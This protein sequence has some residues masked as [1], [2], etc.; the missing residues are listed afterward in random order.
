MFLMEVYGL[1]IE[2]HVFK[3]HPTDMLTKLSCDLHLSLLPSYLDF[4]NCNPGVGG[5]WVAHQTTN[6]SKFTL[7]KWKSKPAA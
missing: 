6:S 1:G 3:P 5:V 4:P 7:R 2:H